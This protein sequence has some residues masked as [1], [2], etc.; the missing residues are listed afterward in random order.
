MMHTGG[1]GV[2]RMRW[3]YLASIAPS[4]V[5]SKSPQQGDYSIHSSSGGDMHGIPNGTDVPG[6][7][8]GIQ[9]RRLQRERINDNSPATRTT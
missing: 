2:I 3:L 8:R 5:T 1:L 4:P 9:A 6:R 7:R